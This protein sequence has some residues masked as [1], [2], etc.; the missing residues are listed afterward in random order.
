MNKFAKILTLTLFF[1]MLIIF[2][3]I[4][5]FN[6]N[7]SVSPKENKTLSDFPELTKETFFNKSYVNGIDNFVL[8]H[9]T[10]RKKLI[11]L[12]TNMDIV[13]GKKE[14]NN[15]FILKDRLIKRFS[16]PNYEKVSDNINAINLFSQRI[17]KDVY[18]MIAP[19][20]AGVYED[21]LPNIKVYNQK[22]FI[23]YTIII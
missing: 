4:T 19:T 2:P 6:S 23:D 12:K 16:E 1:G 15:I 10:A 5:I 3:I 18:V 21:H 14:V 7:K 9:F 17:D 8:D 20:A 22:T 11:S 13:S